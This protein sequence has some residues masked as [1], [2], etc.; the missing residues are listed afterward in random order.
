MKTFLFIV[1]AAFFPLH[2]SA[3][4]FPAL[5]D[6][7]GVASDDVLNVRTA[8][9][10]GAEKIGALSYAQTQVEVVSTSDDQK[11][12]LVNIGEGAGWASMA[13]LKRLPEQEWGSFQMPGGCY[14]TE[15]FWSLTGFDNDQITLEE[16]SGTPFTYQLI[17][18][19][20]SI[21]SIGS[22]WLVGENGGR[23]IHVTF[24]RTSCHD[25]MSDREYGLAVDLYAD[26]DDNGPLAL[27]GC[28]LLAPQ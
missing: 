18:S 26:T 1:L 22:H 28:C 5:Y 20:S 10:A 9:N 25:G 2:L 16:M 7:T 15:P 4:P 14:G 3:E 21:G 8:P 6:V 23:N 13:Y 17:A 12:G 19:M 27:T 11:W 24:R